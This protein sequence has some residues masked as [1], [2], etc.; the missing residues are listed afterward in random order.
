MLMDSGFVRN[1]VVTVKI[2][3]VYSL[4]NKNEKLILIIWKNVLSVLIV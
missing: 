1:M 4:K 2:L 3:I